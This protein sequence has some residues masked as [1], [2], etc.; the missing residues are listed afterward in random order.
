MGLSKLTKTPR[1]LMTRPLLDNGT[2][3]LDQ[4]KLKLI[5]NN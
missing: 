2:R 3:F 4:P 5:K 1:P